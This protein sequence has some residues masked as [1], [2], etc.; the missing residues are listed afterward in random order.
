MEKRR[1]SYHFIMLMGAV[2]LFGDITY[3]G[4]RS[5]TGPFFAFL[6]ASAAAVGA[7]SGFGEFLGYALRIVSGYVADKTKAH[8]PLT[9]IGY[10]MMFAVPMLA[11]SGRWEVAALF[12]I[13]E[14]AGKAIRSPARDA[15]LSHAAKEV[16]RGWGFGLHEFFDQLG[17][18]MGPLIFTSVLFLGKSYSTGFKI[19]FIPAMAA[20]VFLLLARKKLPHPEKLEC[21]VLRG[22][23][24]GE[25]K[26]I[27]WLYTVFTFASV[28][29]VV[30]FQLISYNLKVAKI[31]TDPQIP[32]FYLAA[33]GADGL[34][35]LVVGK[36]YDRKGF[37]LLLL[38]PLL[39]IL[40][41]FA[42]FSGSFWIAAG[43]VILWGLV[44]GVH[45]TIM[46]AAIADLAEPK[47]RGT[48]Y[49]IFNTAYGLAFFIGSALMGVLYE[50]SLH[51]L[52]GFAVFMEALSILFF[53][54]FH[55]YFKKITPA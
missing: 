18:I 40:L 28:A 27:F 29:G 30:H 2:S 16:G 46:R 43:G 12:V 36:L 31:A 39:S 14:R 20:L 38:A 15:I 32:I 1:V 48:A 11:F 24:P 6:G 5:V 34:I 52:F 49:G 9:F 53:L 22:A 51:L 3:E 37:R 21:H 41:P 13:L 42:A 19:L 25:L 26:K 35:A 44:I 33:M 55:S 47:R 45:E 10:G 4:G 7:V 8:W 23:N 54:R 17:A 50:V